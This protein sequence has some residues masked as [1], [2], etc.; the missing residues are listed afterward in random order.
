MKNIFE[1]FKKNIKNE[2]QKSKKVIDRLLSDQ[3]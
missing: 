1:A 3:E 2:C